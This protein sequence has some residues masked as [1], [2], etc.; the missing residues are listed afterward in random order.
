MVKAYGVWGCKV[1]F[2][3]WQEVRF[4]LRAIDFGVLMIRFFFLLGIGF[5]NPLII[6]ALLWIV[7]I[8]II[9]FA[10]IVI[11]LFEILIYPHL[12]DY[13]LVMI[14][15]RNFYKGSIFVYYS[16]HHSGFPSKVSLFLAYHIL[17]MM[18]MIMDRLQLSFCRIIVMS[19]YMKLCCSFL[20]KFIL[21]WD[22]KPSLAIPYTI[23]K[24]MI[25]G[26]YIRVTPSAQG[27]GLHLMPLFWIFSLTRMMLFKILHTN[28]LSRSRFSY[29]NFSSKELL[30]FFPY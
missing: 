10:C 14:D 9:I 7:Y 11:I 19:H 25:S 4:G 3:G 29:D 24:I 6:L 20:L 1:Q 2:R 27:K 22:P 15:I 5:V 12:V 16:F 26:I 23:H 30:L 17:S 13:L 21:S 8:L 18:L 28:L